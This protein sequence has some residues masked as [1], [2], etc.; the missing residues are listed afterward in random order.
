MIMKLQIYFLIMVNRKTDIWLIEQMI[1]KK[2]CLT[3]L[4]I[5]FLVYI[6]NKSKTDDRI[7]F[8]ITVWLTETYPSLTESKSKY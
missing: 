5:R 8:C 1:N 7:I 2:F 4:M 6:N 3:I